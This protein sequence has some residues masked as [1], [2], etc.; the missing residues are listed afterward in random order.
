M[1]QHKTQQ[2]QCETSTVA[3]WVKLFKRVNVSGLAPGQ[4]ICRKLAEKSRNQAE[5]AWRLFVCC[6]HPHGVS[7]CSG[8]EVAGDRGEQVH[9]ASTVVNVH[10][11]H[12]T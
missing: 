11:R 8:L 7:R 3:Y 5:I 10:T 2:Q 1:V 6:V 12:T 9:S 4:A